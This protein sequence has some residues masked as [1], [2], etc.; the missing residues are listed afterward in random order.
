MT[1]RSLWV[2][3]ILLAALP[4]RAADDPKPNT[5]TPKEIADGWLLMFDGESTF[6][7]QIDGESK[8]VDG[9]L[10]LGGTKATAATLT[11]SFPTC[12]AR[13]DYR[14][15]GFTANFNMISGEK[16][17]G[18]STFSMFGGAGSVLTIKIVLDPREPFGSEVKAD[19]TSGKPSRYD[20][21]FKHRKL[22][23]T[24]RFDVP[25]GTS[26]ALSNFKLRPTDT[27]PLFNGKDLTDW[28]I[29]DG[30]K[31]RAK[32]EFTVTKDGE[33]HLKNGP[34]DIQTTGQYDDF[35]LQVECKTNGDKLNSGVFFRCR[36]GEYQNGY[37][38][39]I[40]NG[41]DAAKPKEY[42]VEEYDPKT[43]ELK[44]KVKVKSDALDY[45]TG[46]IYR[47]IP[48]RK[49][50]SKDNEW[51]TMTVVAQGRH[52]AT[53]VNGIAVVDWTDNRPLKDNARNGCR[54]EKGNISLQGHDPTTDLLFRNIRIAEMGK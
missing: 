34:G 5:L 15:E 30:D 16:E 41:F 4:A 18:T 22:R 40:H 19:A 13:V 49:Q 43:N 33:L 9:Q 7:W 12:E 14:V 36:P 29:Y 44:D 51:F 27:K 42:V 32:T 52:I 35:V 21:V 47:R 31:A 1:R 17:R 24:M 46:A 50:A 23:P 48:A 53:W 20:A 10:V 6:G 45:G 38:A 54:L 28:K 26:I 11:T 37:E 3:L 8:I 25:A 2:L 39:Q